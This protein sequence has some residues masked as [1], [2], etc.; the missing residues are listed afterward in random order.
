MYEFLRVSVAD[1]MTRDPVVIGPETT[2]REAEALFERHSF[3]G[4]P[5][6]DPGGRLLGILTKLD[7]LRAFRFTP[8][9]IVP[10]YAQIMEGH[11][12]AVMT[13]DPLSFSPGAPLTRVLEELVRTRHKSFPVVEGGRVVGIVAR[14][15]VLSALRR[16]VA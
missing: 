9:S 11:V 6:V 1:A 12:E 4:L 5:V 2:L 10:H 8:D 7:V 16:T 13:R 15:D 3:N 14:E